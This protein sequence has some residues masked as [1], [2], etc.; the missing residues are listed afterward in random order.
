MKNIYNLDDASKKLGI[1]VRGLRTF[2]KRGEL[3]ARK[4]GRAYYVMEEE[5]TRFMEPS[6]ELPK[7]EETETPGPD[8]LTVSEYSREAGIPE[9]KIREWLRDGILKG[10][11]GPRGQWLVDPTMIKWW[12]EVRSGMHPKKRD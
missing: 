10:V 3:R 12:K 5:L 8:F 1:S 2:I 6:E 9:P 4:R 7:T 11:K